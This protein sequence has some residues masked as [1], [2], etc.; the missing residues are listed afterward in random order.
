MTSILF[1]LVGGNLCLENHQYIRDEQHRL[2]VNFSFF[3][4]FS[5]SSAKI[6]LRIFLEKNREEIKHNL[7]SFS[8][9]NHAIIKSL[10][11]VDHLPI[12]RAFSLINFESFHFSFRVSH[13]LILRLK[14]RLITIIID[15][16]SHISMLRSGEPIWIRMNNIT[17]YWFEEVLWT[18]QIRSSANASQTYWLWFELCSYVL[19]NVCL[20]E[21][22][23]VPGLLF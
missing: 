6:V 21:V 22:R 8:I 17:Y 18:R 19:E 15:V 11:K 7:S 12:P 4:S 1:D 20:S 9:S 10:I 2:G 16:F 13:Y 14:R 3:S 5:S 23:E